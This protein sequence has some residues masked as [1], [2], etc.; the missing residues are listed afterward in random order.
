MGCDIHCYAEVKKKGKWVKVGYVFEDEWYESSR[1]PDTFFHPLT[2]H[3]YGSRDYDL[4]SI[5]ADVRNGSGFAGVDT[6]DG[7]HPISMPRGVPKNVS[8]EVKKISDKWDVDGHSH[9][10]LILKEILEFDWKQT[11]KH[12]G[13][14]SLDE[15]K[16]WM[17]DKK[18]RPESYC[19]G[20]S[21][22]LIRK[23][24]NKEMEKK[25]SQRKKHEFN[26]Y[27]LIEWEE[28]YR[29]SAKIFIEKCLPQ[30]KKLS[31]PNL[32][33][34]NRFTDVRMVFWFDN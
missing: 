21:G 31:N 30:L 22:G 9:S 5:L 12:R 4:F 28:T 19:G 16:E 6:G 11:T 34:D 23:I 33:W 3:P 7:F 18:K 27:T 15:Y 24:S 8:K 1:E 17:K 25:I 29:E 10:W 32:N 26:Y 2:E 13:F 20:V 14:V